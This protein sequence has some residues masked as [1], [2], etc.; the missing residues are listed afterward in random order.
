MLRE[1][2]VVAR[3]T[4]ERLMAELGLHGVTRGKPIRTTVQDKATPCPRDHVNGIFHA[5]RQAQPQLLEKRRRQIRYLPL[6]DPKSIIKGGSLLDGK[7][8]SLLRGNQQTGVPPEL[9]S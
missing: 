1:G 5:L 9:F 7:P 3:C 8:G 4:V 6:H 2:F